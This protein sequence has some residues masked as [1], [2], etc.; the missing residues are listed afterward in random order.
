MPHQLALLR[1]ADR[2][3][4]Q[5]EI[6]RTFLCQSAVDA[7]RLATIGLGI[8]PQQLAGGDGE[9]FKRRF[10]I[11]PTAPTCSKSDAVGAPVVT[12]IG[13]LTSDKGSQ[14]LVEA[15]RLVWSSGR[16]MKLVLA[17]PPMSDFERYWE[18]QPESVKRH[19]IRL[20]PVAGT[21]K[22]DLLAATDLLALPSR[23]DSFGI[24]LLE[25]WYYA[26]PVIG[27]RAG[28]IPGLIEDGED[29]RLVPYGDTQA[30]ASAIIEILS[31]PDKA[32][33]WGSAGKQKVMARFTWDAVYA[34]FSE[35]V[36][37]T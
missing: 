20:G 6:E 32:Q 12:A 26:R 11:S 29:G 36:G 9:R 31:D 1:S 13:P 35:A 15:A 25:A 14:Q 10:A 8:E 3:I 23:T 27:A 5:T 34:R 22:N 4:V 19:V 24:V 33:E 18:I 30:L 28:G 17:G 16:S 2:V 7:H 21:D 37:L